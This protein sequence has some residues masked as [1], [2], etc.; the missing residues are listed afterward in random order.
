MFKE[1]KTKLTLLSLLS[2]VV[3]ISTAFVGIS[4]Y[5][6]QAAN[7]NSQM[8]TFEE[9]A[10]KGAEDNTASSNATSTSSAGA[11]NASST[12]IASVASLLDGMII[13]NIG[14]LNVS[15]QTSTASVNNAT[16]TPTISVKVMT[17]TE[18][19]AQAANETSTAS[20]NQTG[21]ASSNNCI[22]LG[23]VST[24]TSSN[25][26]SSSNNNTST[27][28]AT[29]TASN[30]TSSMSSANTTSSSNATSASNSTST[31]SNATSTASAGSNATTGSDKKV[32]A[33]DGQDF[34][35]GQAVVIFS[36]HNLVGVDDVDSGGHI[37]IKIAMP[38]NGTTSTASANSTN[39]IELRFVESG[40]LRSGTFTFN[41]DTLTSAGQGQ[42]EAAGQSG[43]TATSST[44]GNTTTSSTAPAMNNTNSTSTSTNNTRY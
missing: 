20:S 2:A 27:S 23:A 42:I 34:E 7:D 19:A 9:E 41:G 40:T 39:S 8:T 18:I 12:T 29:S 14:T 1:R 24:S 3:V 26:T 35:P 21:T 11:T 44:S 15:N 16:G 22:E 10:Q 6:A 30:S 38:S 37:S 33:I 31:N 4:I 5:S 43:A 36:G 25:T 17:E 28:N 32:L 13:C